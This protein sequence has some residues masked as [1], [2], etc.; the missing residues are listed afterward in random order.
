MFQT[1]FVWNPPGYTE[2]EVP[3]EDDLVGR[4]HG[5]NSGGVVAERA[6]VV[7]LRSVVQL[8]RP[9]EPVQE[10]TVHELGHTKQGSSWNLIGQ[11]IGASW[12][13]YDIF[14]SLVK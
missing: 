10:L 4:R 11:L 13:G 8:L 5:T 7:R 3:V 14:L 12:R 9:V 6:E 1:N 2:H